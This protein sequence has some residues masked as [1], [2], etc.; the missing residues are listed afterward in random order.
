MESILIILGSLVGVFGA[1]FL[2]A[3]LRGY[4][5]TWLW[6][7]FAV[8]VF[9]LPQLSIVQAIGVSVIISFL[10][11]KFS[12]ENPKE[13]NKKSFTQ[14][15]IESFAYSLIALGGGYVIKSFM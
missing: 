5:L 3:F 8:P 7:W 14:L 10:T 9:G 11:V 12:D 6:L 1:M 2:N 13:E 4:V 15:S